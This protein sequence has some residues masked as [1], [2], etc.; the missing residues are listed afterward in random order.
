[1]NLSVITGFLEQSLKGVIAVEIGSSPTNITTHYVSSLFPDEIIKDPDYDGELLFVYDFIEDKEKTISFSELLGYSH[2]SSIDS[3][4]QEKIKK[5]FFK[6]KE[7]YPNVS[8]LKELFFNPSSK[9]EHLKLTLTFGNPL[10]LDTLENDLSKLEP[11]PEHILQHCKSIW[12]S[13]HDK[14]KIQVEAMI[15]AEIDEVLAGEDKELANDLIIIKEEY[16]SISEQY[17]EKINAISDF[18]ELLNYWH[19]LLLPAPECFRGVF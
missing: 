4:K 17:E 10:T 14:R 18:R 9:L 15:Q 8:N 1:M 6:L 7:E 13:E 11:M 19:P 16:S 3:K 12:L 5:D 2:Y